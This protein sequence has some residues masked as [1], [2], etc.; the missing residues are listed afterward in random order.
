M[1]SNNICKI[2]SRYYF[3]LLQIKQ[4]K[5][6]QY[7]QKQQCKAAKFFNHCFPF[8]T[9]SIK[10]GFN[11]VNHSDLNWPHPSFKW[12]KIILSFFFKII[13]RKQTSKINQSFTGK[14]K[15]NE[16]NAEVSTHYWAF[17][18]YSNCLIFWL[19]DFMFLCQIDF[20]IS[21]G[22]CST[23]KLSK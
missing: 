18:L 22:A 8:L 11:F 23:S 15:I 4:L 16:W 6:G 17:W 21:I 1:N 20:S 5:S 10:I 12:L 9:L 2:N 13:R 7:N 14:H 19:F 3:F